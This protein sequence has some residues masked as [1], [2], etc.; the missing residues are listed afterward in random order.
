LISEFGASPPKIHIIIS[1][2]AGSEGINLQSANVL[3][4][5]D[6]PWNPMIVEQ[7]IG[8]IQRLA[9]E[10]ATVCIFNLIL[11]GTFEEII[12]GRLMEKLQLASQ[13]IGD[14]ESLLEATDLESDDTSDN[15]QEKIRKLVVASLEGKDTIQD[16]Q[17][18]EKSIAEAI[19]ELRAEREHIDDILGKQEEI[20][21]PEPICPK[22]S[23]PHHSIEQE[24]FTTL[25]LKLFNQNKYLREG[26]FNQGMQ[27]SVMC[28]HETERNAGDIIGVCNSNQSKLIKFNQLVIQVTKHGLHFL[29]DSDSDALDKAKLMAE[30]WVDN[31]GAIYVSSDIEDIKRNLFG[32]VLLRVRLTVAFDSYEKLIEL[33]HNPFIA[34]NFIKINDLIPLEPLIDN[35]S[36]LRLSR[37]S[38]QSEVVQDKDVSEF[39]RYY[40]DRKNYELSSAEGDINKQ[41][42]I[43][44]DYSPNIDTTIVSVIGDIKRQVKIKIAYE[45]GAGNTY[46]ST[47]VLLP[48]LN[49][50]IS[51]P[52]INR[53]VVSE[54]LVPSDCLEPCQ[55]SGKIVLKHLLVHS[56]ISN[57]KALP[58]YTVYCSH[59]GKRLLVDEVGKSD[60]TGKSVALAYLKKSVLS[61][62]LAE[63]E[64]FGTCAFTSCLVLN[65]ELAISQISGKRYRFD[66]EISSIISGKKGHKQEFIICTETGQPLL[67]NE[68][69]Q[70]EITRKIV[71]PWMLESCDETNKIVLKSELAKCSITG[72]KVL[73]SLLVNSS[74]S[75]LPLLETLAI[76]SDSGLF[77]TPPEARE[78]LWSSILHHP[79]DL[80]VCQLTGIE[81]Y[82][83]YVTDG[84][85]PCSKVFLSLLNGFKL[86]SD[87]TES[88]KMIADHVGSLIDSGHCI[89][90]AAELSPSGQCLAVYFE[91]KRW[92]GL[93][94]IKAGLF[95]SLSEHSII[96][97]IAKTK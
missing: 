51:S 4:N 28:P 32:T 6:L 10:H 47:L 93:K 69:A 92:M 59:T 39:C 73:K 48:F 43:E 62:K 11:K 44:N 23:T 81:I 58:N 13:A 29:N 33:K 82:H 60:V 36:L 57:R 80:R 46:C 52:N 66:E 26:L 85:M 25:A 16:I 87:Y 3:V 72:K 12:V 95:Y 64:Y 76:R 71:V 7:R 53:C 37:D 65:S 96:G 40:N 17:K 50:I 84:N 22:L 94:V 77:C 55:I 27:D 89:V 78:C 61:G 31:F 70:C 2:E 38:I 19:S 83:I 68:S 5:Y 79:I 42:K 9:S 45:V 63:H 20:N 24:K 35:I 21:L 34:D 18:T 14:I 49:D 1:T 97:H 86:K 15:F 74:I 54:R 30:K 75:Q 88:W 91:I 90:K 56:E 67:A 41:R 8:R